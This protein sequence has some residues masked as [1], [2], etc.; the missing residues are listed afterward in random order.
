MALGPG[1]RLGPYEV[2]APLGAGGFGEVYKARD[3]RLDREVA[4]KVLPGDF[5]ESEDRKERFAR[6]ARSLA[7]LNHP[8]IA[9]IHSFEEIPGPSPSS[10]RHVLVMELVEGQGLDERLASGPL[11]LEDTLSFGRQIAE[12]LAYAHGRG[13]LHRDLKPAN[14]MVSPEGKV[15]LLDFGLAKHVGLEEGES[16]ASTVD[17]LTRDGS[18]VGTLSYMSPEQLL[19]RPLDGRSDLFSLGIVLHEMSTGRRPFQGSSMIEVVDA[20]LHA[21]P[22]ASAD[23]P[24]PARLQPVVGRLLEKDPAK[25]YASAAEVGRDL[26][27]LREP[28]GARG[29]GLSRGAWIAVAAAAIAVAALGGWSLRK[30]SREKW[31]LAQILEITHLVDVGDDP[32]AAALLEKARAILPHDAALRRLWEQATGELS[33]DTDPAGADVS[34]R[35]YRGAETSWVRLG[36]TPIKTRLPLDFYVF[37][38]TRRGFGTQEFVWR[39]VARRAVKLDPDGSVPPEMVRVTPLRP[40]VGLVLTRLQHFPEVS[41]EDFLIDRHEVTND[42]FRKFVDAGGYEKREYWKE[43]FVRGGRTVPWEEAIR[44]FSD[45][46]GRPGP[47]TWEVGSFPKGTEKHPVAGVSWYEAAAYAAFAGK[48]LP[49]VYHWS[50]AAQPQLAMLFV[51]GSNFHE[52]VQP[53]GA[54]GTLSGFGT[55]D[56]AGNVKEW[57]LNEGAGGTRYV[58]GGGFGEPRYMF[59]DIDAQSPW[60]RRPNYGFRCVRLSAPAP[61][62]AAAKLEPVYRDYAKERPVSDEVFRAFQGA[63]AY[64]RRDLN[65]KVEETGAAT[66]WVREKVTIDAAYGGERLPVHLFLPKNV[67]PPF[68]TVVYFPGSS[69]FRGDANVDMS[70]DMG[71]GFFVKSGRALV[72]PVYKS[73][74][75]R[76]DELKN[77]KPEPTAFWR[78]HVI[79]WS[80][81]LGR[82][83]DYLETRPDLDRT[84]RVYFG[85][86]WGAV[87][88][89]VLLATNDRF[90]AAILLG[91]GL[92]FERSHPDVDPLNFLPRVRTPLILLNGR[93]D[94]FFPVESSQVPF[95]RSLGTAE[96]DR[97]HVLYDSGHS[98]PFRE[99]VRDSLDWLDKYLGPVK[100]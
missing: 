42:E 45:S 21:E 64:D 43:T 59:G 53:V 23:R 93:Y 62:E 48:S 72:W 57:C 31:A 4:L 89:P 65:P 51:P 10:S 88:S 20:I 100:R 26:A 70:E 30:T 87:V 84:K 58:L 16:E 8:G 29:A 28:A 98:P 55:T 80:K 35:P 33:I 56:M 15:K 79:M 40:R 34:A 92:K 14:V 37:R 27:A 32:R 60:D 81:D 68:Q 12:A 5:L 99:F 97:R 90:R 73:T 19:A 18:V 86:S 2:L 83:L 17:R 67:P 3:P 24:V 1:T 78:D 82:T 38:M 47:A 50:A 66:R 74:Y 77:N 95:F 22:T 91:G 94:A 46:T 69:S 49:T 39:P 41:L 54:P 63:F 44:T 9:A 96:R 36:Q 13:I 85:W 71:F 75:E 61:A 7:A 6:E 25:R 52:A 11:S 76:Q